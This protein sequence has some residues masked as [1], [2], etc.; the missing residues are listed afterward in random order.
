MPS[1]V[2]FPFQL[3]SPQPSSNTKQPNNYHLPDIPHPN[4]NNNT[5]IPPN[6]AIIPDAHFGC[7][8]L[9]YAALAPQLSH[10]ELLLQAYPRAKH[11]TDAKGQTPLH[12]HLANTLSN[13]LR[14]AR[15]NFDLLSEVC[16]ALVHKSTQASN[17]DFVEAEIMR[18]LEWLHTGRSD[19]RGFFRT[20]ARHLQ[21]PIPASHRY[22]HQDL[23]FLYL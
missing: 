23:P 11:L 2:Q 14:N 7:L 9:H 15:G 20:S 3:H 13:S 19:C 10:I 22:L 12:W 5:G 17:V 21:E 8:P 16:K 4:S 1:H 6:A 18:A